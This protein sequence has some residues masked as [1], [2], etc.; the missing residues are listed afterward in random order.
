[1]KTWK[2]EQF[3]CFHTKSQSTNCWMIVSVRRD[4]VFVDTRSRNQEE[5]TFVFQFSDSLRHDGGILQKKKNRKKK[6][7]PAGVTFSYGSDRK[8]KAVVTLLQSAAAIKRRGLQELVLDEWRL[9]AETLSRSLH[10]LRRGSFSWQQQLAAGLV[11]AQDEEME[12]KN[13]FAFFF[14]P[15][16]KT[17]VVSWQFLLFHWAQ[18]ESK[19][20]DDSLLSLRISGVYSVTLKL[21]TFHHS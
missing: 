6:S 17:S 8:H 11:P 12:D 7:L 2:K 18:T 3:L 9:R 19:P 4:D 1:M 21:C 14:F 20:Q 5:L 16:W 15:L 13:L 10:L